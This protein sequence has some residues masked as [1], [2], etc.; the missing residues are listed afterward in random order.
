M[1]PPHF[2]I[3][4]D[5]L[6]GEWTF[7]ALEPG[8]RRWCVDGVDVDV[9]ALD[10]GHKGGRAYGYR[11]EAGGRSLCYVPDAVDDNDGPIGTLADGVDL[12]VRGA[13]FVAAEQA[14]ADEY[15]HGTV[16]HAI[17]TAERAGVGRLIVT[18]HGPFRTDD[19][20]DAVAERLGV[21]VATEGL[22]VAV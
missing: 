18:H 9:R 14:R 22:T 11:V 12:L 2:P 20:L 6:G 21:R 1:S 10:V 3:R 7:V 16:E 4:P 8:W 19:D 15:G 5:E 13:P 17:A